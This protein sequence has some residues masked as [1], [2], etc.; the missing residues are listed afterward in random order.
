M[1]SIQNLRI[2]GRRPWVVAL[3][4]C[5]LAACDDLLEVDLPA[6]L[7]DDALNNPASARTLVNSFIS[8]FEQQYNEHVWETFGRED[9]G[10]VQLSSGGTDSGYFTYGV[11]SGRFGGM[12]EARRYAYHLHD[13][14][15]QD[16][17][18]AQVPERAR[19]L[20]LSSIYAG[21]ALGFMGSTLCEITVDA[22]E[23]LTADAALTLADEWL[24]KAL[25]EISG[26]GADFAVPY[27][28]STSAR[29][30]AYGLRAQVRWMKGD[31]TGALADAT[32]IPRGFF[33]YVTRE[34]T[35]SRRNKPYYSG[36]AIKYQELFDVIDFWQGLPNPLTGQA[37][38]N[39]IP[40]TGYRNLGILPDGRAVRED[41][42]PIR[43]AGS[44]R[45]AVEDNA[46]ADGRVKSLRAFVQGLAGEQSYVPARYG[47]EGD[48][49]PL[50]SWKE[51][52]LIRAEIEGG[53]RA[54]DLVNE[55]RTADNLPRVTY[56]EPGN[57]QQIRYMIVE[58]RRRSLYLEARYFQTK[59]KNPD[60]LWFPRANGKSP[61]KGNSYQGGVRWLMPNA[62][63]QRNTNLSMEAR[64][65]GCAQH[66]RPV[67]IDAAGF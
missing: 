61:R 62:E 53:Q 30:M 67:N 54:I 33:A 3:L 13:K 11:S 23:L 43:T 48:D 42:L 40:F 32:Q 9:G 16:W 47:T 12:A 38:P 19:Y 58:E 56:A 14:L 4:A 15:E 31:N 41:G 18:A 46:V 57:A 50:V 2:R 25:S 7:T 55:L 28:I 21:A 51:M 1:I 60:V 22:G 49:I 44:Y 26:A 63:Y 24:T 10:E 66:Q 65:T 8:H 36:T 20:A 52:V 64:A 45:T 34:A 27:G 5:S 35:P 39:P 6:S 17:T 29:N 59:L 37:W